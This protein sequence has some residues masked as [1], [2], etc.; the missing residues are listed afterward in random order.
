MTASVV[1]SS[2]S[3]GTRWSRALLTSGISAVHAGLAALAQLALFGTA[4]RALSAEDFGSWT[5]L[6]TVAGWLT[7]SDF[8]LNK[9]VVTRLAGSGVPRRLVSTAFFL[10]A[11]IAWPL[12]LLAFAGFWPHSLPLRLSIAFVLAVAPFSVARALVSGQQRGWIPAVWDITGSAC[13][14][15]LCLGF[16]PRVELTGMAL[17]AASGLIVSR[18]LG[19]IWLWRNAR[20]STS[21]V[22]RDQATDLWRA[23]R[24]FVI[25]QG[26]DLLLIQGLP[27]IAVAE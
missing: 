4:V 5:A 19:G 8:G 27:W 14:L 22:D 24:H 7:L 21:S 2:A 3:C 18:I 6:A 15:L 20:P 11:A 23:G 25:A 9:A 13:L 10:Q 16:A 17:I 1:P 26:A 12:S